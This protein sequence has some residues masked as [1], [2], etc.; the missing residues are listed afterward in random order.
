MTYQCIS[1]FTSS[2]MKHFVLGSEISDTEYTN[3]LYSERSNFKWLS[4][5]SNSSYSYGGSFFGGDSFN[6]SSNDNSS[7]NGFDGGFGGGDF[8]GG[9]AGGDW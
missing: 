6:D 9:G 4:R 8:S 5:S 3:L 7:S 2:G 1:S